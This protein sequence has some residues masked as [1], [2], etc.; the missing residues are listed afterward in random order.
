MWSCLLFTL[1]SVFA[2]VGKSQV[3]GLLPLFQAGANRMLSS[4]N[5]RGEGP[6]PLGPCFWSVANWGQ[7][8]SGKKNREVLWKTL[9]LL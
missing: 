8:N 1:Y 5:P 9:Y 7:T 4:D 2:E 3:L 6:L